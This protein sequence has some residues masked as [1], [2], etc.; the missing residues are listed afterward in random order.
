MFLATTGST[1]FW[2][3]SDKIVVLGAGCLRYDRRPD[4]QGLRY[5]ILSNPWADAGA[6]L[7]AERYCQG[8]ID[9]LVV[10]LS[11]CLNQIHGVRHSRRYWRILLGPWLLFYVHALYDRYVRVKRALDSHEGLRTT[12][13]RPSDY[14][15]PVD[16]MDFIRLA[17]H[18][19]T[20]DTF[21]LQLYS[22]IFKALSVRGIALEEVS[23]P[24]GEKD[25]R[26]IVDCDSEPQKSLPF[27]KIRACNMMAR[28]LRP[29]VILWNLDLLNSHGLFCLLRRMAF[30]AWF[31][32][33]IP[34][35]RC[36]TSRPNE[37]GRKEFDVIESSDEFTSVLKR[38][39]PTNFPLGYLE[40][41]H[42][43]RGS[44][45]GAWPTAPRV[46]V[47]PFGWLN[48]GF[49][50]LAAEYTECGSRLVGVQHGGGYGTSNVGPQLEYECSV[51]N[52]WISFGWLKEQ[53]TCRVR[54]LPHPRFTPIESMSKGRERRDILLVTTSHPRFSF[55]FESHPVGNFDDVL[56]WRT[57]FVQA[58][59]ESLRGHLLI[60]LTGED[61]G[62]SQRHRLRDE[63]GDLRFDA[64]GSPLRGYFLR[65]RVIVIE[66]SGTAYLEALAA[67]VPTVMFWDPAHW[68]VRD[69]VER[70]FED[71]REAGILWNSPEDAARK[72]SEIYDEPWDWWRGPSV[73]AIRHAFVSH[74]A[75]WRENWLESWVKALREEVILSYSDDS[76]EQEYGSRSLVQ[77]ASECVCLHRGRAGRSS[78]TSP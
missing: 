68:E 54:A 6:V 57:A 37:A 14:A 16:T 56:K 65:S 18:D 74:F 72:V 66:Y 11:S 52:S 2:D 31:M 64:E 27:L 61:Y 40:E 13:L 44:C 42:H 70:C 20:A 9:N 69:E 19:P 38:T 10:D 45:L 8:V 78:R 23:L 12:V 51:S 53:G 17:Y 28:F 55:R 29:P 26:E 46:L 3:R 75:L 15:T 50:F 33:D 67:N 47:S 34:G 24:E 60:K 36:R 41:Y 4:W 76:K 21:N 48:E 77:D 58:L 73:Q 43:F 49:K 5:S 30:R 39:L 63:S 62:W 59:P 25:A 22:Q 7:K 32:A 71:L 1:E 35:I